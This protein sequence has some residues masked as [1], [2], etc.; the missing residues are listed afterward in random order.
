MQ[1]RVIGRIGQ[2]I[3]G[4]GRGSPPPQSSNFFLRVGNRDKAADHLLL[5][6]A[7]VRIPAVEDQH[8]PV[9]V[10]AV[11]RLMLDRVVEGERLALAPLAGLTAD[12]K[13]TACR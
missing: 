4:R 5:M 7:E 2:D 1:T 13:R 8:C 10:A 6:F 9:P 12:S 3:F 11:P